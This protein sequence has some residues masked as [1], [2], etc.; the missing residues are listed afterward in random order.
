[1]DENIDTRLDRLET[2]VAYQDATIEQLN[3]IVVAQRRQFERLEAL[4]RELSKRLS[5]TRVEAPVGAAQ[6]RPPHY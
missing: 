4:C 3:D 5:E 6:E 2:R 1:M